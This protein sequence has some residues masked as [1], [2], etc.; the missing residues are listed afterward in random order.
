LEN[1]T[2]KILGPDCG[3]TR[4][5][6]DYQGNFYFSR[7]VNDVGAIFKVEL[8]DQT[9]LGET[10]VFAGCGAHPL[11][12]P[13]KDAATTYFR[14]VIDLDVSPSNSVY[15]LTNVKV[16]SSSANPRTLARIA[17][18]GK[19]D[20]IQ[21][22]ANQASVAE[23]IEFG[24][25]ETLYLLMK[26]S[27]GDIDYPTI[28]G[29]RPNGDTV[30]YLKKPVINSPDSPYWGG[31]YGPISEAFARW[32]SDIGIDQQDNLYFA[33]VRLVSAS[34][35][36]TL[37]RIRKISPQGR[38]STVIGRGCGTSSTSG[39]GLDTSL[40]NKTALL[41]APDGTV[42]VEPLLDASTISPLTAQV[43]SH[44]ISVQDEFAFV[45]DLSDEVYLFSTDGLNRH[46]QTI[47]RFTNGNI[48]SFVYDPQ[49]RLNQ[50]ID[51]HGNVTTFERD[52]GK[53]TGILSPLG[54]RSIVQLNPNGYLQKLTTPGG[55]V[56]E[57]GYTEDGLMTYYK[58]P[59]GYTSTFEFEPRTGRLK[60]DTNAAAAAAAK[61]GI[62]LSNTSG[63]KRN[64]P[65]GAIRYMSSTSI[66]SAEGVTTE[67]RT[68]PEWTGSNSKLSVHL[69]TGV[70][71]TSEFVHGV[72][73][74]V[75]LSR[76]SAAYDAQTYGMSIDVDYEP[77]P[78]F[79][80]GAAYAAKTTVKTPSGLQQTVDVTK[81]VSLSDPRDVFSLT[82]YQTT[83]TVNGKSYQA[84]YTQTDKTWTLRTPENRLYTMALNQSAEPILASVPGMANTNVEYDSAGRISAIWQHDPA[85]GYRTLKAGYDSRGYVQTLSQTNA[86]PDSTSTSIESQVW[87]YKR[88][89]DGRA[90][91]VLLPGGTKVGL[92]YD[93]NG[94][95]TSVT[96]PS[97][98][99]HWFQYDLAD[100]LKEYNPPDLAGVSPDTTVYEYNL[101]N[102]VRSIARPDNTLIDVEY[103]EGV[104]RP[105]TIF[106]NDTPQIDFDYTPTPEDPN[107]ASLKSL[108]YGQT[109]L[110]FTYDADL[111][112]SVS[113]DGPGAMAGTVAWTYNKEFAV[114][115]EQIVAAGWTGSEVTY[116][117]DND[118]LLKTAGAMTL[119]PKADNGLL[120]STTLGS[121]TS[122]R[123]YDAFGAVKT[124]T[125]TLNGQVLYS[126]SYEPDGLGRIGSIT[127]TRSGS[128]KVTE[129]EYDEAGRLKAVEENGN[130][131]SEYDYTFESG[132]AIYELNGSRGAHHDLRSGTAV[133]RQG[134]YDAQDRL[135]QYGNTSYTYTAN[136]ELAT[137]N[138]SGQTTRYTY[139]VFGNLERV[140]LPNSQVLT[141][142]HDAL[143][144]TVAKARNGFIEKGFLWGRQLQPIA[145]LDAQG[146][147]VSRFVY[148]TKVNVPDYMISRKD[149]LGVV[150]STW[151]TYRIIT[152]HLGSPRLV[153]D[154]D[155][156]DTAQEMTY[157]E[158]GNVLSDNRPGFQ[159]FGF[160]GGLYDPDTKLVRF[161]ARD[162]DAF[163]GRWTAK[164]PIRFA[165]GDA[166]LYGYV[167]SDPVNWVDIDGLTKADKL[168][169]LP[170]KFWNWYHRQDK[171]GGTPDL[172]KDDAHDL[173]EEWKRLGE[174]GPDT[175]KGGKKGGG[176]GGS[177]FEDIFD[178]LIPMPP[179]FNPCLL[180]PSLP[181]C[182]PP[183][184]SGACGPTA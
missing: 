63:L 41:V 87:E 43:F 38:I 77:D 98:M 163:T 99:P 62:T 1:N 135:T 136:G 166:N 15:I 73:S 11:S 114:D 119:T 39:F 141:Y 184:Y 96:P 30:E 181:F 133:T 153:V 20:E 145:E 115:K 3:D 29:R 130:V 79:R 158:F 93:K 86:H 23:R 182:N 37:C 26:N 112:T 19:V 89:N 21:T 144:R 24:K 65:D 127:E 66:S 54:L 12:S 178:L 14:H 150:G 95:V 5:V 102:Q 70:V 61:D 120:E 108:T 100:N 32:I 90:T 44:D 18:D 126:N 168:F 8:N 75:K 28:V 138:Q 103:E 174:P 167:A 106:V 33:Q 161:G 40:P 59:R 48:Q 101:D 82:S 81:S 123:T 143:G 51:S 110:D 80:T 13:G 34:V 117:R 49:G 17:A 180:N 78:R 88:D 47:D 122:S 85:S 147:V 169:G 71:N 91:S 154:V 6:F 183:D 149:N 176:E 146:N 171:K 31:D 105:T 53:L 111:V 124:E 36:N 155:T 97:R 7:G 22:W 57:F 162:Y 55:A 173:F 157:D 139:D 27:P 50:M 159:P 35:D 129:Y 84:S 128:E 4:G 121:L 175:K 148:A 16:P 64:T 179:L 45:D 107:P 2:W 68:D 151:H 94:N 172:R 76:T 125:W 104:G 72:R 56:H 170:K 10:T 58:N 74:S 113:L 92:L 116:G 25:D 83:T 177:I 164:D 156:G 109:A 131:V 140:I 69:S 165:G 142:M 9:R 52:A 42:V 67:Y 60:K 160:A 134:T 152:S 118:G 46:T 132:G 137:Q